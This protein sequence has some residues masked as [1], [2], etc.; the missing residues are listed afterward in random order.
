[1]AN[2]L[3]DVVVV[4]KVVADAVGAVDVVVAVVKELI[5]VRRLVD[6]AV[7]LLSDVRYVAEIAA[8]VVLAHDAIDDDDDDVVVPIVDVVEN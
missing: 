5:A 2:D 8:V 4:K 7:D 1:M 6:V 3:I